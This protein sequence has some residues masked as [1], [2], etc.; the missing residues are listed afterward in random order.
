MISK[1]LL[2]ICSILAVINS[3]G[4]IRINKL[5]LGID[6]IRSLTMF[7]PEQNAYSHQFYYNTCQVNAEVFFPMRTSFV[8]SYGYTKAHLQEFDNTLD[9]HSQGS[10]A[11]FGLNFNLSELTDRSQGLIGWRIGISRDYTED[12]TIILQGESWNTKVVQNLG[13]QKRSAL[14]GE[15][16]LEERIRVS[17]NTFSFLSNLWFSVQGSL[18]FNNSLP[19][20]GQYVSYNIPGFGRYDIISPGASFNLAYYFNFKHK[21]I[22]PENPKYKTRKH[23]RKYGTI[24]DYQ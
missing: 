20:P 10:Y 5:A 21:L 8:A 11:K 7:A 14:W 1:A 13:E 23:K 3:Y 24:L 18:R 19:S 9:Y 17:M 16:I 6:P 2:F 22:Y 15:L 12:A 4:Q